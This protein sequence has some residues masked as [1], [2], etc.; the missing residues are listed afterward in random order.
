MEVLHQEGV[1]AATI[2]GL[3]GDLGSLP[4][5]AEERALIELAER[6]TVDPPSA[7]AAVVR[8][9]ELGWTDKQL[10]D[11]IFL[12]SYFNMTTRI[13]EAFALPPDSRHPFEPGGALP[14]LRC[15][16]PK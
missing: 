8:A 12:V 16:R 10:A 9:R 4:L 15:Q 5:A 2:A 11:A 1:D 13:A 7:A 14:M 6:M 3:Q